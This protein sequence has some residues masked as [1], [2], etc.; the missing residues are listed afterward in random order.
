MGGI[1]RHERARE[2]TIELM[3]DAIRRGDW[4]DAL[5]WLNTLAVVD[6]DFSLTADQVLASWRARAGR[7]REGRGD[8]DPRWRDAPADY[9]GLFGAL[10]EHAYDGIVI[11]DAQG[12]GCSN[13][14]AR[15]RQ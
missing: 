8:P 14:A 4:L 1:S 5:Q 3:A 15:S 11:S 6:L 10:L 7:F 9:R 13:A 12:A 2:Q